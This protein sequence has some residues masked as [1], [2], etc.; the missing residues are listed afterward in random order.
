MFAKQSSKK[1]ILVID[2]I[3][4]ILAIEMF[5]WLT[6]IRVRRLQ[7]F[8]LFVIEPVFGLAETI[9]CGSSR[10]IYG[11]RQLKRNKF[12]IIVVVSTVKLEILRIDVIRSC[13]IFHFGDI[14]TQWH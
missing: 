9:S 10:C 14:Y 4:A 3:R 13:Y 8:K 7:S 11:G 1:S 12:Y 2:P 6:D 5:L